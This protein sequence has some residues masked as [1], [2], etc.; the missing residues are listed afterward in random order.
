LARDAAGR[1]MP[2][3]RANGPFLALKVPAGKTHV[4]MRYR[5]PGFVPGAWI[6]GATLVILA[7][8]GL[9][10]RTKSVA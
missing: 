1:A 10:R 7:A 2:L 8:V 5:P 4:R 9:L 6:S 3:S